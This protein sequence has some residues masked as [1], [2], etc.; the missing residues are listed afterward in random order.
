MSALPPVTPP[1]PVAAA[2]KSYI[3]PKCAG[4]MNFDAG[5]AGDNLDIEWQMGPNGI[6]TVNTVKVSSLPE[7]A[8]M[9][10][11]GLGGLAALRRRKA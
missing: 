11:L 2:A 5:G 7:P 9:I 6:H 1:E 8:T 10:L 3:C 4:K